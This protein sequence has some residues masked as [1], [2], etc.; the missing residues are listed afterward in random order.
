M[1]SDFQ[2]IK[3]WTWNWGEAQY[4]L[5]ADS[6]YNAFDEASLG[7]ILR[8]TNNPAFSPHIASKGRI[9]LIRDHKYRITVK[10]HL[11]GQQPNENPVGGWLFAIGIRPNSAQTGDYWNSINAGVSVAV[12]QSGWGSGSWATHSIEV[13]ANALLDQ[14]CQ[15]TRPLFRLDSQGVY[16]V[17][18]IEIRDITGELNSKA[19]A[20]AASGSANT[21]SIKANEAGQSANAAEI[22]KTNAKSS[23]DAAWQHRQGAAGHENTA[24]QYRSDAETFRNQASQSASNASGSAATATQQSGVATSAAL[25]A[26]S[27]AT[28]NIVSR[29][30]WNAT[31][32]KGTWTDAVNVAWA[33]D[34]GQH[35]LSQTSRDS[36]D[37]EP[38]A[39]NWS[40][41]R[42][43]LSGEV[44]TWGSFNAQVGLHVVMNDGSNGWYI[45]TVVNAGQWYTP[46]STE[47]LLPANVKAARGLLVSDGPHGDARNGLNW[48]SVRIE[49]ITSEKAASDSASAAANS[50]QTATSKADEAGRSASAASSSEVRA[51]SAADGADKTFANSFPNYVGP[52]GKKA[53]EYAGD[54]P[55]GFSFENGPDQGWPQPYITA[56][57]PGQGGTANRIMFKESVDKVVGRRYRVTGWFYNHGSNCANVVIW[58]L[59]TNNNVWDGNAI[60][61][62]GDAVA[63]DCVN[64][65]ALNQGGFWK[66][67]MEFTVPGHW[68]SKWKPIFEFATTGGAPNGLWHMTGMNIEDITSEKAAKDS[69]NAASNEFSKAEIESGKAGQSANAASGHANT[70]QIKAGEAAGSANA[71]QGSAATATDKASAAANSATLA[72]TFST[73]GGNLLP[74]TAFATSTTGWNFYSPFDN[75]WFVFGRDQSGDDWRPTNEH[76]IG[77]NQANG[78]TSAWSQFHSD[79]VSVEGSKWYEFSGYVAAHR[80]K[81]YVR[82]DWLDANGNGIS[83]NY[84]N[85]NESA[86][87]GGRNINAWMRCWGKVQAPSNAARAHVVFVKDPTMPGYGDSYAWMCRPMLRQTYAE[88]NGPS[89]YAPGTNALTAAAQQASI[90]QNGTAIATANSSLANLTTIVQS[91]SPN[92]LRNGGF[93]RGMADWGL[94]HGGWQPHISGGWGQVANRGGGW[95]G[96]Y[97]YIESAKMPVFGNAAYTLAADSLYYLYSGSGHCYTE[98]VWFDGAGNNV[99][100]HTGG[101]V[102]ASH[103]Y[104]VNGSN[105]LAH[106]LIA[107]SPGNATQAVV[108]LVHYKSDNTSVNV[109]GWRQ[110]KFE[111]GDKMTAFSNEA[112]VTTIAETVTSV[113]GKANQALARAGVR[114]DVNGYMVG[115]EMAN[116]GQTGNMIV[117]VDSF[118]LVKPGGG[119]RTE[120][121]NGCMKVFDENGVL[122]GRFGNLSA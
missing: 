56:Q 113:D 66:V 104:S 86:A 35:V 1:P 54:N 17:Q 49:D 115:W 119:A 85:A 72:A 46:F 24:G 111:Q 64:N 18:S 62:G 16:D 30:E 106:K 59:L 83:S 97:C 41:R 19:S 12:G 87:E 109:I 9:T 60:G 2:N 93:A 10:W 40:N 105:R 120:F 23:E 103:D 108:R 43:R 8:V 14:G 121:V 90:T 79:Q 21:A 50:A 73:G 29:G 95:D 39:G 37:G 45:I 7:R 80:C 94:T 69:A 117:N 42:F 15:W 118:Q 99:G 57:G 107:V 77:I 63:P 81:A 44:Q 65:V 31:S 68:P 28:G 32:G 33:A 98:M 53:Y 74:E 110:V 52:I 61:H 92:L 4:D 13:D 55:A 78:D 101:L 20:D 82:V 89:P 116:N 5:S 76:N 25:D 22:S 71:A 6:R 26:A 114:L 70:A 38:V 47:L 67:G 102:G 3:N 84:S 112:S 27:R 11:V 96:A 91:G 48:R 88:A 34:I 36:Y 100:Q 122:R 75:N 58:L 51:S